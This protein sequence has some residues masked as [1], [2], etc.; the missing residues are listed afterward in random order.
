LAPVRDA[1]AM[2]ASMSPT[3][4]NGVFVFCRTADRAIA[5]A[6]F[7]QAIG[8]FAEAEGSS[9]ILPIAA[10]ERLGVDHSIPMRLITLTVHSALD[11]VGL[12]SAV[13]GT[14]ANLQI[15]CN[16]VAAFHHDHVFVPYEQADQALAALVELQQHEGS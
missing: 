4:G 9:F 16:I 3:L 14:L 12:T 13:A 1:K 5:D 2:I 10:A 11:G 8:F 6:C 15:P 7:E